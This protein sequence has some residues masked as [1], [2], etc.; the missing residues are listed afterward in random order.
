[1]QAR[2]QTRNLMIQIL[3]LTSAVKFVE[4]FAMVAGFDF[5]R[6]VIPSFNGILTFKEEI[7]SFNIPI[8]IDKSR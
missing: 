4:S 5:S 6:F 2:L 3:F 7:L 8:I 1:M